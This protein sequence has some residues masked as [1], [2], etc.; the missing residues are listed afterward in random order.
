MAHTFRTLEDLD[1][2]L[3][4]LDDV[5]PL[6]PSDILHGAFTNGMQ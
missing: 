6:G 1:L 2:D 3:S 4:T 5:L